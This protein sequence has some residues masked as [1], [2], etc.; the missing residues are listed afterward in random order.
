MKTQNRVRTIVKQASMAAFFAIG[1]LTALLCLLKPRVAEVLPA[2]QEFGN[3][4]LVSAPSGKAESESGPPGVAVVES[5]TPGKP[6]GVDTGGLALAKPATPSAAQQSAFEQLQKRLA[7]KESGA[8]KGPAE[9]DPIGAQLRDQA[10]RAGL[11]PWRL[12]PGDGSPEFT[13]R[14]ELTGSPE[15]SFAADNPAHQLT[16]T[17]GKDGLRVRPTAH[18]A[19]RPPLAE[20]PPVQPEASDW[21]FSLRLTGIGYGSGATPVDQ[22]AV[23]PVS[24]RLEL[25]RGPFT[26]WYVNDAQGIEHGFTLQAPP[27]ERSETSHELR[28]AFEMTTGLKAGLDESARSVRLDSPTGEPLLRYGELVAYDARGR[29]LP[30][31]FELQGNQLEIVVDDH[32]AT[33]PMVIDPTIVSLVKDINLRGVGSGPQNLV[34]C[35]GVLFF[36]AYEPATGY[37]LWKSDGTAAGTVLVKDIIPG[38]GS[39]LAY[40]LTAVGSTL[41]FQAYEPTTGYELWKSDGTAAGTVLVKDI[42]PGSGAS[43]P[44]NLTAVGST[45]FFNAYEPTAGTELWKSDGTAAGTVLV[46]DINPGS[47]SGGAFYLTAVGSTLY[48]I[49]YE[50]A[51]GYELWKSD[52]TAAGT[53]LVKDINPGSGS[54]YPQYLTAVGSTL[55]FNAYEPTT[56]Q[57]LWKSD[58]TAAGTVLVKDFIPGSGSG[59]AYYLTAAGSTLFFQAYEQTT[60]YELWKSDGTAAGTVLVKDIIPGSGSGYPQYLTAVGSTL[61][62]QAYEPTTGYELWKSDGTAAGTVLVKDINPGSGSGGAYYLTAVASTLFFN[63]YE[64]TTGSELWKSD[65]TAAGNGAGQGHH[66][67]QRFWRFLLSDGSGEHVVLQRL[68]ADDRFRVVEE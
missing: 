60:G 67:G 17:F 12:R 5:K 34:S 46:K 14:P 24:N 64:P 38:S 27:A 42:N 21:E 35:G 49:A 48:F 51:R 63:A 16:G 15:A 9:P 8:G 66:P 25:N 29:D 13:F 57:E 18:V 26:E 11:E 31:R 56:G 41:F 39:G 54:S 62:F 20:M 1:T 3:H 65:G 68:R 23:I 30:A 50:P 33:Y 37:E 36:M 4:F 19:G 28:V 10:R 40:N 59:G 55:L 7:R 2:P 52:G 32:D 61:F 53:A 58:G 45:L 22:E 44:Y 43:N 6:D 47:D